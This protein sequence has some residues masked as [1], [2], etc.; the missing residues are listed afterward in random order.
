MTR[1]KKTP[2]LPRRGNYGR[3]TQHSARLFE[4]LLVVQ[5]PDLKQPP[6]FMSTFL[7]ASSTA[8]RDPP[9]TK[10]LATNTKFSSHTKNLCPSP[11]YILRALSPSQIFWLWRPHRGGAIRSQEARTPLDQ[12]KLDKVV[13]GLS[14][15]SLKLHDILISI[16]LALRGT[17]RLV[18]LVLRVNIARKRLS[19]GFGGFPGTPGAT[20][21]F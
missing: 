10:Q 20:H 6:Y 5:C 9:H 12:I 8:S 7:A 11:P 2:D 17:T 18:V 3:M 4:V 16:K 19:E 21:H 15:H 1:E 13:G 14:W